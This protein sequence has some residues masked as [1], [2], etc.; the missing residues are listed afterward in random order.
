MKME[1]DWWIPEFNLAIEYQGQHHYHYF[2]QLQPTDT[3]T[4]QF[5]YQNRDFRKRESCGLLGKFSVSF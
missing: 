2:H 3:S 5:V 4:D 1:L